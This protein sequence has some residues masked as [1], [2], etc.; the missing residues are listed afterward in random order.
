MDTLIESKLR[1]GM[2]LIDRPERESAEKYLQEALELARQTGNARLAAVA[3]L[4]LAQL[5]SQTGQAGK[6]LE[7]AGMSVEHARLSGDPATIG[8]A[9]ARQA[10]AHHLN[11]EPEKS[12]ELF[13][14]ALEQLQDNA[15]PDILAQTYFE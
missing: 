3:G 13:V 11:H 5:Y 7:L 10:L 12:R 15:G 6:A 9:L 14:E 8:Q 1:L 4:N 2:L